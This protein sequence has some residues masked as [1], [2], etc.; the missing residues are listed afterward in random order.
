MA[1]A[2]ENPIKADSMNAAI[3]GGIPIKLS[4]S[5]V[6]VHMAVV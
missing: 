6:L 4:S 1:S 2:N 5:M 3:L